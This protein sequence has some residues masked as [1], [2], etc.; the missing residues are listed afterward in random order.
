MCTVGETVLHR[1]CY[2]FRMSVSMFSAHLGKI[3][4]NGV[5]CVINT[6]MDHRGRIGKLQLY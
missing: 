1:F 3:I 2:S 5:S 4:S 6:N